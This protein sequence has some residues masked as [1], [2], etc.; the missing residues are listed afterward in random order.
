MDY[1]FFSCHPQ[2]VSYWHFFGTLVL[3]GWQ[4]GSYGLRQR[5]I[6]IIVISL[7]NILVY[8]LILMHN[9][10]ERV[11]APPCPPVHLSF[12]PVSLASSCPVS[13]S[14]NTA[15]Q[16]L[17][18][19]S[20]VSFHPKATPLPQHTYPYKPPLHCIPRSAC[21]VC[22][23]VCKMRDGKDDV[24]EM[25]GGMDG[26]Q[27]TEITRERSVCVCVHR[28]FCARRSVW[29][30]CA[31]WNGKWVM[32]RSVCKA[33]GASYWPLG[34]LSAS[35]LSHSHTL[36]QW[37]HT[38]TKAYTHPDVSAFA[39]IYHLPGLKTRGKSETA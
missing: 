22:A 24:F 19:Q 10:F 32:V 38:R 17:L 18:A 21:P 5:I 3:L 1:Y 26:G 20:S 33:P 25:E 35:S 34:L 11:T 39:L 7:T 28:C 4:F 15:R 37:L 23:C 8:D 30:V 36:S 16:A 29:G 6:L 2:I 31:G 14:A 12:Q 9:T 13:Q 27:K